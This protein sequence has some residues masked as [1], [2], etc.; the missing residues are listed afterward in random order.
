MKFGRCQGEKN[1]KRRWSGSTWRWKGES[2]KLEAAEGCVGKS[3]QLTKFRSAHSYYLKLSDT[4]SF[5]LYYPLS[6][7]FLRIQYLSYLTLEAPIV[8]E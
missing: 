6:Y 8:F 1:S 2:E 3:L 5:I 7:F 4:R